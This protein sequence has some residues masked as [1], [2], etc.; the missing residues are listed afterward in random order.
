V[1]RATL[2]ALREAIA[3]KQHL[4]VIDD[5]F[6]RAVR[7]EAEIGPE[8]APTATSAAAQKKRR[9]KRTR[10]VAAS[11]TPRIGRAEKPGVC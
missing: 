7:G 6:E 8:V 3:L 1:R 5:H 10:A 2:F 11:G 4:H 9:S